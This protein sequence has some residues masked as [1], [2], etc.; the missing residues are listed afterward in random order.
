MATG[1]RPGELAGRPAG[2]RRRGARP[3]PSG[4][5]LG[6]SVDTLGALVPAL[7]PLSPFKDLVTLPAVFS[8]FL[9]LKC[10]L[11]LSLK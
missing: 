5:A 3:T 4:V 8:C 10:V 6:Q 7:V 2:R 1:L 11:L 9:P